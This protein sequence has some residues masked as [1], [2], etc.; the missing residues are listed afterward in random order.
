MFTPS[1]LIAQL[2][3]DLPSPH[4]LRSLSTIKAV[5]VH[6]SHSSCHVI[7]LTLEG[8]AFL[9]G[10][11]SNGALGVPSSVASISELAPMKL[12]PSN[13][14]APAGAKFVNAACGRNHSLLI[15]SDGQ[16]WAAGAN[17]HGQCGQVPCAETAGFKPVPGAWRKSDPIDKPVKVCAGVTFSLVLTQS[18]KVYSFG[19]GDHG[20]LGNGRTGE[21]IITGNKTGFDVIY[22]PVHIK[23]FDKKIVNISTGQQHS[24]AIDVEGRV[25]VWGYNGYCRLGLGHQKDILSPTLVPQFSTENDLV[26]GLLV[27][28]GPTNSIIV[29]RQ[30]MYHMAGKWKNSGEGSTGQPYTTFRVIA[31]IMSCKILAACSGGVTHWA[32][33]PDDEDEN[34]PS[35]P[36]LAR[37]P[38]KESLDKDGKPRQVKVMTVAWG[39]NAH[40]S[41]LGF[42]DGEPK[43]APKPQRVR[44]LD[45]VEVFD[46]AAGQNLTMFLTV[47]GD[48]DLPRH[49]DEIDHAEL[50][51][52]CSLD[53]GDDELELCDNPYHLKCLNPPLDEVPEGEWFCK[54]CLEESER[55]APSAAFTDYDTTFKTA[56]KAPITGTKRKNGDEADPQN[57]APKKKR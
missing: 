8:N 37:S 43:S 1:P 6:T 39:Q 38:G 15:T 47:P 9:F 29:D 34:A 53:L 22:E 27:A 11:N 45:G 55:D 54:R 21:H 30:R 4:I 42:G 40:N 28:A 3:P 10:R 16:V 32:L 7:V 19:S 44:T 35:S 50:C 51:V 13:I 48:S 14:G 5:S 20:Q 2:R 17:N 26:R 33:T 46:I 31:D 57:S 18:G 41:E 56:A 12:K 36:Q 23:T 52:V 25:F 24:I 49:P